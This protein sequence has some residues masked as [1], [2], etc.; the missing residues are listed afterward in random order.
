MSDE[1]ADSTQ[2]RAK[3]SAESPRLVEKHVERIDDFALST[4]KRGG[5]SKL[6]FQGSE[7]NTRVEGETLECQFRTEFG[8]LLMT[9][10]DCPFEG[11]VSIYCLDDDLMIEDAKFLGIPYTPA[12]VSDVVMTRDGRIEFSFFGQDRWSLSVRQRRW[13]SPLRWLR[14]CSGLVL[15]DISSTAESGSGN[16]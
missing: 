9:G 12:F 5:R 14:G 16:G 7:I 8:Y 4:P 13:W 10:D 11:G 2:R 15:K 1:F 6:V 3:M